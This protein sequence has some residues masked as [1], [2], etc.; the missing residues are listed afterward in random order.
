MSHA[1]TKE[2]RTFLEGVG[3][4]YL[5]NVKDERGKALAAADL[6][7]LTLT[8]IDKSTAQV[9]NSRNA[10]SVLN[11][12]G[13][14]IN[15]SGE[16]EFLLTADDNVI[17]DTGLDDELEEEHIMRL[18]WTWIDSSLQTHTG[19]KDIS[20]WVKQLDTPVVP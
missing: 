5:G 8:L 2:E 14:T 9:I 19:G 3:G 11:A 16:F 1:L 10:V 13:G 4:I 17:V 20:I 7:T 6:T 12:N 15:A 18:R